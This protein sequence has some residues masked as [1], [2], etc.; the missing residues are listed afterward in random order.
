MFSENDSLIGLDEFQH[1]TT[2]TDKNK[3]VG[4]DG[5]GFTLL[6]LFG[7]VGSLLSELKKK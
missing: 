1:W 5:I 6:G 2:L 3:R 4:V 7:E